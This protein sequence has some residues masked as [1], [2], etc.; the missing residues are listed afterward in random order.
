M[1]SLPLLTFV[2]SSLCALPASAVTLYEM[3]VINDVS[4]EHDSNGT[5]APTPLPDA[6]SA[7]IEGIGTFEWEDLATDT[8]SNTAVFSSTGF[9]AREW[10]GE[11]IFTSSTIGLT[12]F[13]SVTINAVGESVSTDS[14]DEV[15][16]FFYSL[17]GGANINFSSGP[18]T[19]DVSSATSLLVGFIFDHNG[20]DDR[21]EVSELNV[22]GIP[23]PEPSTVILGG[24]GLFSFVRCRR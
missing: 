19:L 21:I 15:F 24:L 2:G 18:V 13:D 12:S 4:F 22:T 5:N 23:V 14:S 1:K 20:V 7:L 9:E 17:D 8:T 10:G 11:G 6:G 16:N 3:V